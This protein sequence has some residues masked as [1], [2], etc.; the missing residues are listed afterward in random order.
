MVTRKASGPDCLRMVMNSTRMICEFT[1]ISMLI[2]RSRV[3][4]I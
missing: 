3:T 1:K 2:A 4:E